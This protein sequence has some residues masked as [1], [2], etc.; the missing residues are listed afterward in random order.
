LIAPAL[1][2]CL[3]DELPIFATASEEIDIVTVESDQLREERDLV[4]VLAELGPFGLDGGERGAV[5]AVGFAVA[6]S[7]V[8]LSRQVGARLPRS[9]AHTS[10][11]PSPGQVIC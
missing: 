1:R 7:G 11:L 6:M 4:A 8:E 2:V 5:F 3:H 9:E 10:E